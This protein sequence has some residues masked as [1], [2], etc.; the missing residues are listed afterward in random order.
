MPY[1]DIYLEAE[2]RMDKTLGNLKGELRAT[3][4]ARASTGLVEHL[5]VDYYGTQTTLREIANI[6]TPDPRMIV[7]RAYD[8]S[9]LSTI[10]KAILKSDL[11]MAPNNDGKLIRLAVPAL[12][13]ERRRQIAV[14]IKQIGEESKVAIRNIRRDAN[15]QVD[16]EEKQKLITEDD[17]YN[18]KKDIQELTKAHE[19]AIDETLEAKSKEIME[20]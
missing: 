16:R 11:G 3:R 1:D 14:K 15:K 18:I 10:E 2:E 17:V 6:T 5:K 8:P 12:S 7:I 20:I 13:E 19:T 4:G 9:I